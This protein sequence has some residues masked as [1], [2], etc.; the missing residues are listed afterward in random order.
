MGMFKE[1]NISALKK[2]FINIFNNIKSHKHDFHRYL[3][4]SIISFI[5]IK[6]VKGILIFRWNLPNKSISLYKTVLIQI[7][8]LLKMFRIMKDFLLYELLIFLK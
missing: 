7:P 4:F 8:V 6:I 1:G 5:I 2:D 3:Y